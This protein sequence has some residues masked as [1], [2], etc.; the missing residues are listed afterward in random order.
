M[1]ITFVCISLKE[2]EDRRKNIQ[3]LFEKLG[4]LDQI[5]WWIVERHPQAG[6]YGCF[7]THFMV[8]S[9]DEIKTKYVCVF[10]DDLSVFESEKITRKRLQKLLKWISQNGVPGDL[11]NLEPGSGYYGDKSVFF[12]SLSD[13]ELRD[14]FC[15]RTGCYIAEKKKLEKLAKRIKPLYGIDF[16]IALYGNC[17]M[18]S[19]VI[20][21]FRQDKQFVS[22]NTGSYHD[23][24][25]YPSN[26]GLEFSRN[27]LTTV[28]LFAYIYLNAFQTSLNIYSSCS[29]RWS[30][31]KIEDL[32]DRRVK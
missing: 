21:I 5:K 20:P 1:D 27:F 23:Y 31:Q 32:T 13:S 6:T 9:T 10:E 2:R 18:Y 11:I 3:K 17:D 22:D 14:G 24:V 12:S 16:D 8:W 7:E 28:P 26:S 29:S 25:S 30:S 4:I 15:T 19:C